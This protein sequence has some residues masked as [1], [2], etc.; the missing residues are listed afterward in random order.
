MKNNTKLK[1]F[2]Y[3]GERINQMAENKILGYTIKKQYYRWK[4]AKM[5]KVVKIRNHRKDAPLGTALKLT[6]HD[7]QK[8]LRAGRMS[9]MVV[10]YQTQEGSRQASLVPSKFIR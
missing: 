3:G 4:E 1:V 5:R 8:L 9:D 2:N 10:F 7:K 6:V